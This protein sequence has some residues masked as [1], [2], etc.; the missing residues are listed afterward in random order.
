MDGVVR[1]MQAPADGEV[2]TSRGSTAYISSA[3]VLVVLGKVAN[4]LCLAGLLA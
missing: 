4:Q 2:H 3:K 1:Y